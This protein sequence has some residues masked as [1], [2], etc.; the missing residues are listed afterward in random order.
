MPRPWEIDI[1]IINQQ[2]APD[3]W[4]FKPASSPFSSIMCTAP[5]YSQLHFRSVI[6]L[7]SPSSQIDLPEKEKQTQKIG[8]IPS[9]IGSL[10]P[11][12]PKTNK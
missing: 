8:R 6:F 5:R 11:A 9:L 4:H 1:S 12:H 2:V 3:N 10:T 7:Q